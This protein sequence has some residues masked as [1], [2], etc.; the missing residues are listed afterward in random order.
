MASMIA[1]GNRRAVSRAQPALCAED[2][3]FLAAERRRIPTHAGV[4]A[5]AEQ[6]ARGP[7]QKH[8]GSN[9]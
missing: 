5:P 6:V 9:R 1:E 3:E 7:L 2:Q 4:L 8:L